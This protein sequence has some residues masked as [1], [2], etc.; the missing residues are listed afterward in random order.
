MDVMYFL[1]LPAVLIIGLVTSYEDIKRGIIRNEFIIA[2]LIY[3][4]SMLF[5]VAVVFYVQ[6]KPL[7]TF[8]LTQ[9][10]FNII[11]ALFAAV[12]IW[13]SGLWSA[14]DA[15]LFIAYAALLPLSVYHSDF[16]AYFPA[17]TIIIN[18][19]IPIMLFYATVALIRTNTKQKKAVIKSFIKPRI[20]LESLLFAFAFSWLGSLF[21][22][23]TI[24][25]HITYVNSIFL[26]IAFPFIAILFFDKILKISPRKISIVISL[27]ALVADYQEIFSIGFLQKFALLAIIFMIIRHFIL[28]LSFEAFSYPIYI[29]N[30]K[31]KM[32]VAENFSYENQKYSKKRINQVGFLSRAAQKSESFLFTDFLNGLSERDIKKIKKLHSQGRIKEHTIRVFHTTPFAPFLFFG[33]VITLIFNGSPLSI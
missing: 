7:S 28:N 22:R 16:I 32:L 4:F 17:I 30:L 11:F 10:V 25:F 23:H 33:V 29:E 19:F 6:G 20:F 31:P 14:G 8:Y 5:I 18:T 15:K 1:M 12:V 26:L 13:L 27:T 2:S 9:S 3:S 21:F 24:Q